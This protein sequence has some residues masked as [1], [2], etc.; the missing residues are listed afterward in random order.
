M[1]R[2]RKNQGVYENP[3]GSGVWW[4]EWYE[5]RKRNRRKIGTLAMAKA[6]VE[7]MR[8]R[9]RVR[10]I[11]PELVTDPE[12]KGLAEVID[13]H[14]ATSRNR[15]WRDDQRYARMW[16]GVFR[17]TRLD[18]VTAAEIE[19]W[20]TVR[21]Q[22]HAPATVNREL[23]FLRRVFSIAT[24]E[25]WCARN[26]VLQVRFCKLNN[27]RKRFLSLEEE[28]SL[29]AV[30]PHDAWLLVDFAIQTG[31]RRGE[32][33][34][35]RRED[36]NLR[37]KVVRVRDTK[38]GE[39]R[40]VRLNVAA[41]EILRE[42]LA[43]HDSDWVFPSRTGKTPI[44]ANNFVKRVFDPALDAAGIKGVTWHTLRHTFGSRLAQEGAPLF[45]V[46]R[47]MGHKRASTTERYAHLAPSHEQ[48]AVE[49]L[50][51][52]T[53]TSADIKQLAGAS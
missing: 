31:M 43:R 48:E 19:K 21:L 18:D 53:A 3:L 7:Q 5:G 25:G 15:S 23:S 30:M 41:R 16:K 38:S 40:D 44:S 26:P 34:G 8:A 35:L 45:T 17:G 14:V 28:A 37:A 10:K 49:K 4:I 24:R 2:E 32:Q 12:H 50:P 1:G 51:S 6:A 9:V 52:T 47:L 11:A 36:V 22:T 33:F 46:G 42:V 29:R 39:G 13:H 20:M 27:A